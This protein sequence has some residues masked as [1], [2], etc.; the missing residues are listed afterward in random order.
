MG[1][2]AIDLKLGVCEVPAKETTMTPVRMALSMFRRYRPTSLGADCRLELRFL[3]RV[4]SSY[5]RH[6]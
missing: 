5:V 1:S 4:H 6:A 2:P 3:W